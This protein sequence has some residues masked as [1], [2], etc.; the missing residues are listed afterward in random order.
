MHSQRTSQE[1]IANEKQLVTGLFDL[2][3][4]DTITVND[5][6]WD[7]R[8]YIVN[9]GKYVFKFPRSEQV[10]AAYKSEIAACKLVSTIHSSVRTPLVKWEGAN[11]DY[12]GYEGIVGTALDIVAHTLLR[13]TWNDIGTALGVFLFQLHQLYL[14]NAQEM[15]IDDEIKEFQYKYSLG[16]PIIQQSFTGDEQVKIE[17]LIQ[18]E[19]PSKLTALGSEMVLCH[20]DLGYWNIIYGSNGELGV[21]D[22]GDIGYYD[23]SKDFIGLKNVSALNAALSVYGDNNILREK[24]AL[25]KKVLAILDLPFFIGKNDQAGI[26]NTVN[27]IRSAIS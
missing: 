19:L 18:E 6:G 5:V 10:K 17:R 22:F 13:D 3:D 12:F 7:S 2:T 15:S 23:R 16:L 21:I 11:N 8:V 14:E 20:G 25:R 4:V 1:V 9:S 27:N 26:N 24:I